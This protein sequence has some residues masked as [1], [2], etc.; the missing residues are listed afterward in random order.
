MR[1][2]SYLGRTSCQSGARPA[3]FSVSLFA[4]GSAWPAA[5]LPR[6]CGIA[7][8]IFRRAPVSVNRI[9][10]WLSRSVRSR[11]P[12]LRGS[13]D[14]ALKTACWIDALAVLAPAAGAHRSEL[15]AHCQ[16]DCW[17]NSTASRCL[18]SLAAQRANALCRTPPRAA[19]AELTGARRHAEAASGPNRAA[20]IMFDPTHEGASRILMR[21]LADM[22]ERAQAL[23]EFAAAATL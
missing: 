12:D 21:A 20:P 5:G 22:G 6:C 3:Q 16:G 11:R 1:A 10:N 8:P 4:A 7:F 2:T 19:R 18:R 23:R 17:R 13:R 15:A 14:I 9:R